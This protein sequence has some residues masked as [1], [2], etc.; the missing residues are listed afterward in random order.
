MTITSS[1][2][3]K[4]KEGYE[5][6]IKSIDA[7][8]T[9]AIVE[10]T[11]DGKIVDSKI[12][13]P[14]IDNAKMADKTYCYAKDLGDTKGLVIMAIHFKNV[15]HSTDMNLATIDGVFQLSD[16]TTSIKAD[17]QY[18]KMSI[19]NVD[20]TAMKISMDNKD[21]SVRLS[22]NTDAQ[23]MQNVYV[24]AADQSYTSPENP[25]RYT[26]Y[27]KYTDPGAYQLRGSVANLGINEFIWDNS[28][29]SG[30]YYDID[31]NLG[32][33]TL[34]FMLTAA[35]P[36][37]AALSDQ[38]DPI[39]GQRGIT[40]RTI[41][42]PKNFKFKPWGQYDI[43][44]F[45]GDRYFAA[46]NSAVTQGM[47][48]AR[49][50]VSFLYDRS[51]NRNFM[52]NEQITKVLIDDDTEQTI[53]SN[54]SLKLEEGYKLAIKS[55]NVKGT[56]VYLELT[57]NGQVVD[58]KVVQP[59]IDDATMADKTY[60]YKADLGDTAE[61]VQI[62]VYFKNLSRDVDKVI[63]T[64]EGVF[65]I[66]DTPTPIKADQQYD[67]MSIR[68]VDATNM[69]VTMDNKDNQI[70]LSK[71]KDVVLMRNIH[72]KTADQDTITDDQPLRYYIYTLETI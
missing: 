11:K 30:F 23:L 49:E 1:A 4:L 48:D 16:E 53:T 70:T 33:E 20:P 37:S 13:H 12:I 22:R 60:Y 24:K 9:N 21:N 14:S 44:G 26:I 72:I 52:T 5:L 7:N 58:S 3:L 67:K 62:A 35:T 68:N 55:I 36:G 46:Y 51:K 25:L 40:Y 10:L 15:F 31:R 6:D 56:K 66:S 8:E 65:Q 57:K 45:L 41:A 17:Q 38:Q 18:G 61:I 39:A 59:S 28:T 32:A 69:A 42:Q 50:P 19:R 29:F 63:A 2:P 71:N 34:T 47:E 27:K 43:I 54:S 64:I